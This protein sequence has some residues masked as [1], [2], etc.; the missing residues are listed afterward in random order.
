MVAAMSGFFVLRVSEIDGLGPAHA[1][2]AMAIG[3]VC[4]IAAQLIG[5]YA[6]D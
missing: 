6:G 3:T 5:G 4:Q 2:T 1:A